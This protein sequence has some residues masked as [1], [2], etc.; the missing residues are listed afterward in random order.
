[1]STGGTSS[2]SRASAISPARS[3]TWIS[4]S[5]RASRAFG[6]SASPSTWRTPNSSNASGSA[7]RTSASPTRNARLVLSPDRV[8]CELDGRPVERKLAAILSADAEGYSRLMGGDEPATV[9]TI[10]EY[11]EV[12]AASVVRHG[13]R[14][15][16]APGDNVLAEF[17]SVVA[18]AQCAV[19]IQ[20]E[21]R[22]RNDA[23]P[24]SCRMPF[25]IGINLGDVIVEGPRLYGD[26]VNI[27]ARLESLAEGG[28]ICLSGTA[29]DQVEGK[30]SLGYEF[31]GEHTVKNIARPVRV[32]RVRLEPPSP[33]LGTASSKRRAH[34]R[35][36][37]HVIGAVAVV[38]LLGVAGWAGW[39]W[40]WTSESAGLPLPDKPSVAVLPFTN[41]SQDS[42]QEY[43]SD[44]VTE[45]VI[46]SL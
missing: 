39:R 35:L 8:E 28:G 10:T 6:P 25:R 46:T 7:I 31:L 11:R 9:R 4:R 44:G 32:Y 41:L 21:L 33:P 13:G 43:F 20:G 12:I 19:E 15:V 30:L 22:S 3:K 34:G 23:L 14:V 40:L 29:Y 42:T 24:D 45:D 37:A 26:G 17:P 2:T 38:M 36:V 5:C 1:M 18:A 16:D 27:A